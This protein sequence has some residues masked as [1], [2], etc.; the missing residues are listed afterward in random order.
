MTRILLLVAA[1]IT[2]SVIATLL[3]TWASTQLRSHKPSA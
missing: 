3:A 1:S 2:L